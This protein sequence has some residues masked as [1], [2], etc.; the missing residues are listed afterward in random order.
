MANTAN[1]GAAPASANGSAASPKP[2]GAGPSP[3][4]RAFIRQMVENLNTHQPG[5]PRGR[6]TGNC[7]QPEF[8]PAPADVVVNGAGKKGHDDDDDAAAAVGG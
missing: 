4:T 7:P 5:V 1:H 2:A 3:Q 8:S 6:N